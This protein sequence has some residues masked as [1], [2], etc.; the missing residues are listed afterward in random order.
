MKAM[1]L[2]LAGLLAA[3]LAQ[4]AGPSSSAWQALLD[5]ALQQHAAQDFTAA[6]ASARAALR[7]AREGQGSTAPFVASSLNALAVI[8][9]S[10]GHPAEAA[11][12]LREALA[13]SEA[14][15]GAHPNTA[16]LAFNLAQLIEQGEQA[17]DAVP[18]YERSLAIAQ[19]L[20]DGE[21]ARV[22]RERNQAAL[23]RLQGAA[24]AEALT[25]EAR[26]LRDQGQA[27]A[28]RAALAQ[29]V[30]IREARDP[31]DPALAEPLNEL[32]LW[33]LER[34]Q[35]ALAAPLLQRALALVEQHQGAQSLDAARLVGTQALLHGEWGDE[36][37]ATALHQRARSLYASHG[38]L[39]EALL[40]QAQAD[41]HLAGF[42]YRKRRFAEAEPLFLRAL[43]LTEQAVGP[44]DPR[45]LPVLDNLQALY[46][47]QRRA[48]RARVFARRAEALRAQKDLP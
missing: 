17:H 44:Q 19:A 6:E 48:D 15:L 4:A 45:L 32:A 12:L 43:A 34:Q 20:P 5:Q 42:A 46:L 31:Q 10:Q 23:D 41:N 29:V 47:S 24:R 35:Y 39:P 30:A 28:A 33:H 40:G 18:L 26:T 13:L 37:A 14:T 2:L 36:A 38:D 11:G 25:R 9:Q 1:A 21:V 7:L 8:R 27:E 16:S 3:G 22:L